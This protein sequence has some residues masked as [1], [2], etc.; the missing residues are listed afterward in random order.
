MWSTKWW[1]RTKRGGNS[2]LFRYGE[3]FWEIPLGEV[4]WRNLHGETFME[5][6][7]WSLQG[8]NSCSP[9]ATLLE[10]HSFSLPF[11]LFA[12]AHTFGSGRMKFL[13]NLL[14]GEERRYQRNI[15][16]EFKLDH[17]LIPPYYLQSLKQ[18]NT[19]MDTGC[20]NLC[21]WINGNGGNKSGHSVSNWVTGTTHIHRWFLVISQG[22]FK[23]YWLYLLIWPHLSYYAYSVAANTGR[24]N[25]SFL[26]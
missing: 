12:I 23:V 11:R 19:S 25:P 14:W 15:H 21:G 17:R 3:V 5:I 26:P 2:S 18:A 4:S 9:I 24:R 6:S 1:G 22:T 13:E 8:V 7:G 10:R 16:M 20:W